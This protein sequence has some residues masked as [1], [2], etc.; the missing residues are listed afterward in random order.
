MKSAWFL[1]LDGVVLVEERGNVF[2]SREVEQGIRDLTS[3][4]WSVIINSLRFPLSIIRNI[5]PA[6]LSIY[7][8]DIPAVL[9]NGS[10]IGFFKNKDGEVVFEESA[11]FPLASNEID[12]I[13]EGI[14]VALEISVS[15]GVR[16][17]A[18]FFYPRDW[19]RGEI[20]WVPEGTHVDAVRHNY[21]N[22]TDV[23]AWSLSELR[24]KLHA[25][26]ICMAM[27][28]IEKIDMDKQ[29]DEHVKQAYQHT[30]PMDFFTTS[31]VN[32]MTGSAVIANKL[33]ISLAD[34]AGAGDS[35]M[36]TFLCAV[37]LAVRVGRDKVP[38]EGIRHTIDVDG[39]PEL[40]EAMRSLSVLLRVH[41]PSHPTYENHS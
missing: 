16:D 12:K 22:A 4:G 15:G 10:L 8:A 34:S 35:E 24:E 21:G 25:A 39:P 5:G 27:L 18:F 38:F 9:M 1:D 2:V 33:K 17:M 31:G 7:G 20:V 30:K 3:V 19:R 32:K 11:A 26:D 36:D 28:L 6:W 40:G 37:G 14:K 13:V 23:V 41:G 29:T